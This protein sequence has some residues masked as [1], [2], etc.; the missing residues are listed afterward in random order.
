MGRSSQ[1]A[2]V[3]LERTHIAVDQATCQEFYA[4]EH[5]ITK[6]APEE[7]RATAAILTNASDLGTCEIAVL[8]YRIGHVRDQ[9]GARETTSLPMSLVHEKSVKLAPKKGHVSKGGVIDIQGE[10][11]MFEFEIGK[12]CVDQVG[13]R[14][15]GGSAVESNNH[16]AETKWRPVIRLGSE[17]LNKGIHGTVGVIRN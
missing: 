10:F 11:G 1:V 13:E 7:S 6:I 15:R 12:L 17:D 14:Q 8:E 3:D 4:V 16:M 9:D 5:A 2:L